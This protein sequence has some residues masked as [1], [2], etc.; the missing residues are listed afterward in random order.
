MVIFHKDILKCP[1][2]SD[3]LE[4]VLFQDKPSAVRGVTQLMGRVFG[5]VVGMEQESKEF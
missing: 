3:C 2:L 4:L 1:A 5:Q